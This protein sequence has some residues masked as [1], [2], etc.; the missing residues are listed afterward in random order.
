MARYADCIFNED[1]FPA[2]GGDYKYHSEC[3]EI[4]WDAQGISSSDPRTQETKQQVQKIIHLQHIANNLPE[5]FIDYKGVTKSSY[6][7]RNAP[8][9]VEVPNKNIQLLPLTKKRGRSTAAPKDDAQ[10]KR[11]RIPRTKSTKSVNPSQPKVGR[12]PK[13][14][15]NPIPGP[16]PQPGSMVHPNTDP[17]TSE[18]P[19]SIVL[20]NDK[21]H[22]GV[23]EISISYIDSGESY[24]R[25]TTVVNIYFS[26]AIREIFL[27]D[28]DPK[29]MAEC[30]KR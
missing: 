17:G 11:Q 5:A 22:K 28:P 2:L 18:H 29:T 1:H 26:A 9:R 6:P 4:N 19:D 21:S 13:V 3:Q 25:K 27:N 14:D 16:I 20:G 12:R 15:T 10:M 30:K 23:K 7:A 8:E 24:D